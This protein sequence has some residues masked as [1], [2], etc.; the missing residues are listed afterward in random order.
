MAGGRLVALSDRVTQRA[1]NLSRRLKQSPPVLDIDTLVARS[2]LVIECAQAS[3]VPGLLRKIVQKRKDLLILST[4]GVL[5]ER[6]LLEKGLV[7]GDGSG[8][9]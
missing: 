2:D 9:L 6:A 8:I 3:L 1:E 7:D 4:G 5:G